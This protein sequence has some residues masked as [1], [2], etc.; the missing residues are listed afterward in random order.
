MICLGTLNFGTALDA[1]EVFR[2][3]D[4]FVERGGVA[5]DSANCY[6]SWAGS[7]DE[8]ELT[9]GAWHRRAR[10]RDRIFLATKVGA[11]PSAPGKPDSEGL[12]PEVIRS[13][14]EASLR[15]LDTD[16]VDVCFAHLQDDSVPQGEML[17]A[18]EALVRAGKVRAVGFSNHSVESVRSARDIA[19]RNG[20]TPVTWLQ[21]RHTYLQPIPGSSFGPQI[22]LTAE[23][24]RYART[25]PDL[26][27]Q[28]YSPLLSGAYTRSDKEFWPHYK[29]P[30]NAKRFSALHKVAGDLGVSPNHVVLAWMMA[31]D[32]VVR[33]VIGVS[34]VDQLDD[35]LG[36]SDLV[37]DDEHLRCLDAADGG[38]WP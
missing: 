30:G 1:A 13:A 28:G 34:S 11:R 9:I 19:A 17:G 36:A 29:H 18:F 32:P 24:A 25:L 37:L 10:A 3:L 15:R 7:G 23:M 21:Q 4:R 20:W 16:R 27:L 2:I 33:P 6:H 12:S 5:V 35:C 38:R 31:S 8:S 22:A 26:K 14:V